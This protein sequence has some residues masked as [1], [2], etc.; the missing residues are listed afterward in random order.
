MN[1]PRSKIE[2]DSKV[3]ILKPPLR[4]GGG[5]FIVPPRVIVT[6]GGNGG[7]MEFNERVTALETHVEHIRDD[8]SGMKGDISDIKGD[9]HKI[10]VRLA[11][12]AGG[13]ATIMVVV[14]WLLDGKLSTLVSMAEAAPK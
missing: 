13:L 14:G 6:D 3:A 8:V 4:S 11:Y 5:D 1:W 2:G 7:G 9:V 12:V 10:H